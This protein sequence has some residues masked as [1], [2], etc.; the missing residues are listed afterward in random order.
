MLVVNTAY[1]TDVA[2]ETTFS[3]ACSE[4]YYE[5]SAWLKN[6][7]YKC[8]CDSNGVGLPMASGYIPTAA[9]DSSGVKPNLAF[10]ING[11]DYYTTGDLAYQGL[12]GTQTG[13]DTLNKWVKRS[14]VYKT[15]PGETSFLISFRNNAPGG[16]GND[17]AIDDIGVRTCYPSM[18]YSPSIAPTVCSGATITITDTVRSYYSNLCILQMAVHY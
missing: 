14:F 8:G 7:C 11:I 13:S 5:I 9:G 2:F 12:G 6:I 17:W 16:G 3:G 10:Q 4:T 15:Q 18:T 1:R